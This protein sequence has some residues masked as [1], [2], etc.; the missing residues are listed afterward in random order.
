[1]RSDSILPDTTPVAVVIGLSIHGLAV[2]RALARRGVPVHAL[3]EREHPP[4]PAALTR[5]AHVHTV[6]GLNSDAL[7]DLLLDFATSARLEPGAVL[8]PT[9]DRM[10]KSL[11][12]GWPRLANLFRL[13]WASQRDEVLELQR[14]DS[15]PALCDRAGVRYP[16]S[17]IVKAI[18]D[19]PQTR[20]LE[21]PL[22]VKPAQPLSSFKAIRA[23]SPEVLVA[24]CQRYSA[25]FPFVVQHWIEG[26]EPSLYSCT[27]FLERGRP[28]VTFTS[29]KIDAVPRGLGQ[30]TVFE[31]TPAPEVERISKNFLRE[32]HMS[33]PIAI[34]FKRDAQGRFWLIEPNVG[35]TE[36]CVDVAVQAGI[37]LP[38][39]EYL[40][41]TGGSVMEE[42]RTRE[43][44]V[45]WFDTDKDPTC[46]VRHLGRLRD[47]EGHWRKRVFPYVGHADARPVYAAVRQ[48]AR[49]AWRA[50]ARRSTSSETL[51][52]SARLA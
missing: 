14:K 37:N 1:M 48:L 23:A 47:D 39:I 10:A 12:L 50:V 43:R 3:A 27:A 25:D 21:Y 28:I 20:A 30:G 8:F 11:A 13:S 33:G 15:L 45:I 31:S 46:F 6:Q 29:R 18:D 2:A 40:H 38:Y 51:R 5:Y 17:V 42:I 4:Q 22:V 41:A 26:P 44:P 49:T 35:R 36:Y 7:P 32:L 34:E 19:L 24:T 9:S 52:D 16:R